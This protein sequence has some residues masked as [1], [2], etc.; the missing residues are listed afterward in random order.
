[1]NEPINENIG[2]CLSRVKVFN[3]G[4]EKM[5]IQ[6]NKVKLPMTLDLQLFHEYERTQFK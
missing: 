4:N 1:M 6:S 3:L 5:K 2:N